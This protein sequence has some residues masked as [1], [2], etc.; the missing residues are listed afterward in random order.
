MHSDRV[1]VNLIAAIDSMTPQERADY[2]LIE[3]SRMRR[4]AA[5][6]GTSID[7][8]QGMLRAITFIDGLRR[9]PVY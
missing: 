7:V 5:G 9:K 3:T 1:T 6:S 4:I 8:I 2:T